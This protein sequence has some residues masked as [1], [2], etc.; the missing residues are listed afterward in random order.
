M[1]VLT[2]ITYLLGDYLVYILPV[3]PQDSPKAELKEM[4]RATNILIGSGF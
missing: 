2:L 1:Y 3:L 4:L